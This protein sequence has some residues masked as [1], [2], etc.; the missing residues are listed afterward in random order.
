MPNTLPPQHM[1]AP[2]PLAQLL[3]LAVASALQGPA[4]QSP[5]FSEAPR[6]V[7]PLPAEQAIYSH[8]HIFFENLI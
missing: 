5:P 2:F 1:R 7:A 3:P 6:D 4:E 8:M